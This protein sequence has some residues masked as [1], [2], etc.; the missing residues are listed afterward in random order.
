MG[1]IA[2]ERHFDIQGSRLVVQSHFVNGVQK[3]MPVGNS[4]TINTLGWSSE[5]MR[6]GIVEPADTQPPGRRGL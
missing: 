5:M 2:T 1:A 6:R 4:L 3:L